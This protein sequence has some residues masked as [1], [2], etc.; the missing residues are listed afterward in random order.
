M[1]VALTVGEKGRL[2]LPIAAREEAGIAVGD[3][4]IVRPVSDGQIMLETRAAIARRLRSRFAQGDGTAGLAQARA[5]DRE[6]ESRSHVDP[7]RGQRRDR[8]AEV[9]RADRILEALEAMPPQAL[10]S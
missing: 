6:L 3:E 7:D 1:T 5:Q 10:A 9:R 8:D 4:L 2:N